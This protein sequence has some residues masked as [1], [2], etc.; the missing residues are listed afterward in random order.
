MYLQ[1]KWNVILPNSLSKLVLVGFIKY[2]TSFEYVGT[3]LGK[4]SNIDTASIA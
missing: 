4:Q 1:F 3:L 2:V